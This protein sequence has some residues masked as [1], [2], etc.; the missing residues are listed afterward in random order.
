MTIGGQ[1]KLPVGGQEADGLHEQARWWGVRGP[2]CRTMPTI[3]LAPSTCP[4]SFCALG[5]LATVV[6]ASDELA[7]YGQSLFAA[8]IAGA[9]DSGRFGPLRAGTR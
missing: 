1:Y 8:Q 9:S 5:N 3:A 7:V 6:T 2:N 4:P